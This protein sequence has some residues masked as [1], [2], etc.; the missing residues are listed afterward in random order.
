LPHPSGWP[1]APECFCFPIAEF[2]AV[3]TYKSWETTPG[4]LGFG[5]PAVGNFEE[6]FPS[7]VGSAW[8]LARSA[9]RQLVHL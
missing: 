8:K 9:E 1:F 5:C 7:A 3:G 2:A 6:M 4:A